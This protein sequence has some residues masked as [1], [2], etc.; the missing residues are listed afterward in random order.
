MRAAPN[1][2]AGRAVEMGE[3]EE[4][5]VLEAVGGFEEADEVEA[6]AE[7]WEDGVW[8]EEDCMTGCRFV[9]VLYPAR[10]SCRK[11]SRTLTR[12]DQEHRPSPTK[13]QMFQLLR[14]KSFSNQI[15]TR[16]FTYPLNK[17]HAQ[18]D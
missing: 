6:C 9:F 13:K 16:S 5:M 1:K 12:M 7:E 10:G 14:D 4:E 15:F 2:S 3:A 18:K 8:V 17:T 11:L